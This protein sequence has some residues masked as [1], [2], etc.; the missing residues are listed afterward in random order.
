MAKTTMK[1]MEAL[2]S[3]TVN[4][5]LINGEE[6][7]AELFA[8]RF[9]AAVGSLE[10]THRINDLKKEVARI[11]LVLGEK[12]RAGEDTSKTVKA[13]YNKAVEIAEKS[14]KELR[15]KQ[16][17]KIEE[18]QAEQFGGI[19]EDAINQAMTNAEVEEEKGADNNGKK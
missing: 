4:D 8:L 6:L 3:K 17:K 15:Q 2:R 19:D 1:H 5:L 16:R 9:Q 10:K 7:R 14:G 13:D 12:K 18:L 11:Q